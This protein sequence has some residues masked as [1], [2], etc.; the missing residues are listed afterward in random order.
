MID[1]FYDLTFILKVIYNTAIVVANLYAIKYIVTIVCYFVYYQIH[2]MAIFRS[3]TIYVAMIESEKRR[4]KRQHDL[5][6]N[7]NN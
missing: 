6:I 2:S 4:R 1:S 5:A 3:N 7:N